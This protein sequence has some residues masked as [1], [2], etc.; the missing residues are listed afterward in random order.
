[1]KRADANRRAI[2]IFAAMLAIATTLLS[3]AAAENQP[4]TKTRSRRPIQP[5]W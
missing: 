2:A 5:C 1:M 3:D 4:A